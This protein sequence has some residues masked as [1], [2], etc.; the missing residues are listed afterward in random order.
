MM[1]FDSGYRHLFSHAEMVRDLLCGFVHEAWVAQLDFASL[2]KVNGSY[3]T[4]DLKDRCDDVIWRVR[5]GE[6]WLYVYLLLEFQSKVDRWMAVRM[7][8][9][10]ML[11]YQDLIK[12]G[13]V[14][15]GEPLPPVVPLVLYN[16]KPD[17]TAEQD[18]EALIA[19][20]PGGLERYRPRM[21]YLLIDEMR[22]GD[23]ELGAMRN[24]VAALFRLEKSRSVE[25]IRSAL[26]CLIDWLKAPEQASLRRAFTVMLGRVLLP[27]RVPGQSVPEM[28]DLQEVETMLA[29]TVQEWTQQWEAK[30]L[31]QGRQ[32]GRQ[33][34]EAAMLLRQLYRRFG[35]V[36]D[37][38][39]EKVS[40][41]DSQA[42]EAWSLRILDA[43]SL[44]EIFA[45]RM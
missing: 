42:L 24:L 13:Q 34:G 43:Q 11:L 45:T 27:R 12:S 23:A 37:W 7:T 3:V 15:A 10:T 44:D 40:Q 36:P 21:R 2:E 32:E 33:E 41:A 1:A 6:S 29:E 19:S 28:R 9:Y 30:G 8:A 20:V 35:M 16:G 22:H 38:V 39:G 5:W 26:G 18:V 14:K 4:D 31:L 25:E 17:W